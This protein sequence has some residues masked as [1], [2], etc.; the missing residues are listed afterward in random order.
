MQFSV[1]IP[2]WNE[3]AFL[4]KT[5]TSVTAVMQ[6]VTDIGTHHGELIVVD[7]NSSDK[8]A[9]IAQEYGARV[10]FE[11]VNQIARAR[12]RGAQIATGE[13]LIFLDADTCCSEK[14]LSH[15][16]D[17][18]SG[19]K[20]VGGGSTIVADRY[21]SPAAQRGIRFW[22]WIGSK[23]RLAAGCFV[24]CRRDAFDAVGGFSDRVYAGEEIFL[25]RLLKRWARKKV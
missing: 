9:A 20:V 4:P 17:K 7:N 22:N 24:Y 6:Q 16:L 25:S 10:V 8:T 1:I 3:E 19:G 5:L 14:L 15:V 2:A 18:L 21:V 23:A 11:P 13:A 12:N